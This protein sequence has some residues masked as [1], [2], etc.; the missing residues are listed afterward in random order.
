MS[1]HGMRRAAICW[2]CLRPKL[3]APGLLFLL[4]FLPLAAA[5]LPRVASVPLFLFGV[6][7][8]LRAK[9]VLNRCY[10]GAAPRA[11]EGRT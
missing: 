6:A 10:G 11:R 8:V 5:F 7:S 4:L 1:Y 3:G 9:V 2:G